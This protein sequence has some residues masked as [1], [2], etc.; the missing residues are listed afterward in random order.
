MSL[1]INEKIEQGIME[2]KPVHGAGPR[3]ALEKKDKILMRLLVDLTA[4]NETNIKDEETIQVA[5]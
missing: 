5:N 2:R 1:S 3:F 4:R